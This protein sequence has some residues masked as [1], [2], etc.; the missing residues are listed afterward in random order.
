[1]VAKYID[2]CTDYGFKR[3]FGQEAHKEV[4]IAFLNSLLPARHQVAEVSFMNTEVLPMHPALGGVVFDLHCVTPSG[5]RFIVEMQRK[6]QP[7]F[8]DRSVFY[9]AS[10]IANM[11][12]RGEGVGELPAVYFIGLMDFRP[13]GEEWQGKLLREAT[14]KDREGK[15]IYE[16]LRM[17]FIQLPLFTKAL[18]ELATPLEMW[19]YYLKHLPDLTSI[20]AT[21]RDIPV[22]VKAF[23]AA[24]TATM[25][26][27]EQLAYFASVDDRTVTRLSLEY[28]IKNATAKGKAEGLAEGEAK[29]EAK[30]L[31]DTA[32][33]MK[34]KG[35]PA[36]AIAE[37]TGLSAEEIGSIA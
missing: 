14:L 7:F 18:D 22:F 16:K 26:E 24:A 31:Y 4:L 5:E 33:K 21:F 29:G 1:M 30:A 34:A 28:D 8:V 15:E 23:E 10:A 19:L 2:P 37:M 32:R 12:E 3:V 11:V 13:V 27:A 17:Y 6:A 20:P 36:E 25:T 35:Y 9:T